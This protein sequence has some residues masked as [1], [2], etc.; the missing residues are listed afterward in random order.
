M[1]GF[2]AYVGEGLCSGVAIGNVFSSPSSE[3]I[4]EAT[5]AVNGGAGVL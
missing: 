5:K 2:L 1:P 3:Q 4:F